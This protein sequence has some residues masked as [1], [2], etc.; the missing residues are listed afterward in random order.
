MRFQAQRGTHDVLPNEIHAWQ[1]LERA[2][3][4][5]AERYGYREIRTPDFEDTELFTQSSGDTSEIVTK[6]MYTFLDKGGRSI[7]LKPEGTAPAVRAYIE[8]NLGGHGGATRLWYATPIFRYERPSLGRFRQAHQVG[9]ELIGSPSPAADAEVIEITIRFY[10][11]LGLTDLRVMVNS[12]GREATRTA[13]REAL[14]AF[15]EPF[16]QSQ[17]EDVR[18]QA[19]KN[20]LR[21]LDSKDPE[22][23]EA[24]QGAP[25]VLDY[26]EDASRAHFGQVLRHLD[27]AGLRYVVDPSVVRG[28]DYY[29]D[30]VFEVQAEALG[31]KSLCGGGRYDALVKRL[32]GADTPAVGVA[33][34]IERALMAQ[35][36]QGVAPRQE[37]EGVYLVAATDS[38]RP[39]VRKLARDLRG[40][41]VATHQ[42]LDDRSMKSQLKQAD[43]VNVA[44][45]VLIGDDE[46]AQGVV[47][48]R[49]MTTSSQ[50]TVPSSELLAALR[51]SL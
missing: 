2:F 37:R 44:W 39:Q 47:T 20:P 40:A 21:M 36:E 24:L 18:E 8:H 22:M 19:A 41:G 28:L 31:D 34:G 9:L 16:L 29:T 14:L 12:L 42:D 17:P 7:T 4:S 48:L 30:T 11:A 26:L 49:D 35:A 45:A 50:R 51:E 10:E 46:I 1:A 25:N 13:Y 43:R 33:M 27:E 5:L 15:A 3:A 32:G 23:K 6:Q 38:A